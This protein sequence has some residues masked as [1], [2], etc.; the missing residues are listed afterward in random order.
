MSNN[1]PSANPPTGKAE[2]APILVSACLAGIPCRYDGAAKPDPQIIAMVEA[3]RAIPVCAE[4]EGGLPT[5]R[6][7]AE[8]VG[9]EGRDVLAGVAKVVT[10]DGDDVTDAFI[11]GARA[12][13]SFARE[14]A[15]R[16][17]ILQDKS[18]SCGATQVYDG[19]HGGS[20]VQGK[21]VLAAA[22]EAEGLTVQAH[23]PR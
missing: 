11:E 6:P 2:D 20:L 4:A 14:R 8:I 9:G 18:P 17:A 3:G 1:D 23:R 16:T 13:A 12:V 15:V 22:L 21:G 10:V 5:P 19:T 7:P